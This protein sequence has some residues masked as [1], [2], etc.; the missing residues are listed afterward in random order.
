MN[1]FKSDPVSLDTE[2][3]HI[4]LCEQCQVFPSF[5][6]GQNK[7]FKYISQIMRN[8]L[9]NKKKFVFDPRYLNACASAAENR[10]IKKSKIE[11]QTSMMEVDP[12]WKNTKNT[13]HQKHQTPKHQTSNIDQTSKHQTSDIETSQRQT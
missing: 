13:K 6:K 2:A 10:K 3:L 9:S 4:R 12:P 8:N 5:E 7:N 11:N 1:E